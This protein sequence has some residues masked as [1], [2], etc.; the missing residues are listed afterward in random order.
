MSRARGNAALLFAGLAI[1]AVGAMCGIGG[2]LFAVPL[3]H[4]GRRLDLKRAVANSQALVVCTTAFATVA[5][6]LRPAP[7]L[8]TSIVLCAMGGVVVGVQLGWLVSERLS[9]RALRAAF[10]VV[11]LVSAVRLFMAGG[12]TEESLGPAQWLGTRA[13]AV[14]VLAGLGGGF[15]APLLGVGGG[16]IMVP[17]LFLGLPGMGFAEA[18]ATSLAAGTLA[19]LRSFWLHG[20]AGRLDVAILRPFSIGAVAGAFA[21]VFLVQRGGAVHVAR[22]LLALILAFVALR[23]LKDLLAGKDR[24]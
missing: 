19:A 13:Y 9:V 3:L 8:H 7:A 17:A 4:Y 16:L 11:L 18:R 10:V 5:E 2:G 21:G 24:P 23:F 6:C 15:I 20:R 12:Q 14:S 22:I 1:S